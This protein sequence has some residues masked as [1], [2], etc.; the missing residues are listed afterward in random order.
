MG[1]GSCIPGQP[2][3]W[4]CLMHLEAQGS[5]LMCRGV[6]FSLGACSH[7]QPLFS[8]PLSR[9]ILQDL[10]ACKSVGCSVQGALQLLTMTRASATD[11]ALISSCSTAAASR[12]SQMWSAAAVGDST[13]CMSDAT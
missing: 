9:L 13:S 4:V 7:Q 12:S 11:G 8:L 2:C 6:S 10:T 5:D 3:L 1:R